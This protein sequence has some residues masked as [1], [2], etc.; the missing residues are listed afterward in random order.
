MSI[1]T[2]LVKEQMCSTI[3]TC[4]TASAKPWHVHIFCHRS[5]LKSL[6][7]KK[8][9]ALLSLHYLRLLSLSWNVLQ[10]WC[11]ACLCLV[12]VELSK[13]HRIGFYL[14]HFVTIYLAFSVGNASVGNAVWI[15]LWLWRTVRMI[16]LR[17]DRVE[18]SAD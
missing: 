11:Q 1:R 2:V 4:S 5:I 3:Y 6:T 8:Y 17:Q 9:Y 16:D 12:A 10:R 14:H 18:G 13:L 15:P 7:T